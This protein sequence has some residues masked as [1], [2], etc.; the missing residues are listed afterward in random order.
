[1]L[2][3]PSRLLPRIRWPAFAM[4]ACDFFTA[5]TVFLKQI[6]VLSVVKMATRCHGKP[7]R[8]TGDPAT[9]NLL[10]DADGWIRPVTFLIRDRDSTFVAGFDA[11]FASIGMR[12]VQ[13]PQ[14]RVAN[15]HAEC[16]V[17][18]VRR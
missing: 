14:A 4:L 2:A 9:R 17:V 6:Y 5:D 7:D 12:V 10:L 8:G 16:S 18:T 13:P 1:M 3:V 15:C 11:V